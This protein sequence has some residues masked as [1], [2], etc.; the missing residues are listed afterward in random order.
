MANADRP[1]GFTPVSHINGNPTNFMTNYYNVASDYSGSAI[2]PGDI[3][4]LAG[5]A[6]TAGVPTIEVCG[7]TDIPLGVVVSFEAKPSVGLDQLYSPADE[8]GYA[9]VCDDPD[10]IL[11][12]QIDG[13]L[14]AGDTGQ[15]FL[16][17]DGGGS[18]TSNRSR[19]E[20][21]Y[22]TL[23]ATRSKMFK[24]LRLAPIPDNALGIDAEVWVKFNVHAHGN[25]YGVAAL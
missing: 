6:D 3:V 22:S 13:I 4:K 15:N 1:N 20:I 16:F 21:G 19:M 23:S 14:T 24:L 8:L 10:V 17:V 25:E 2:F 11:Q 9:L 12:V 18:T 5:D 7:T